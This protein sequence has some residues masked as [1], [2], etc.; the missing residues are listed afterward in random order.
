VQ[1][2]GLPVIADLRSSLD[3]ENALE[4]DAGVIVGSLTGL[5]RGHGR[6]AAG[7]AFEALVERV[8]RMFS[9][10]AHAIRQAHLAAAPQGASLVAL[11]DLAKRLYP[12]I[13]D[14][15]FARADLD[16]ILSFVPESEPIAAYGRMPS[17]LAATL[18]ARRALAWQ[19]D[20]RLG[21]VR[22]PHLLPD[23]SVADANVNTW[24]SFDISPLPEGWTR[25][26]VG[27]REYYL[28]HAAFDGLRVPAFDAAARVQIY[29][30]LPLW[31]FAAF[32]R[33]YAGCADV[34][35]DQPQRPTISI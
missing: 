33:G 26:I 35:A 31:L 22:P 14:P 10:S 24:L 7:P 11:D 17:W 8:A 30:P 1:S 27:K 34:T 12:N 9:Y 29:G 19:F 23:A 16:R 5:M 3:G 13:S 21:W 6:Q 4:S 32:G 15:R 18:G 28:D 25:L 2:R 20:V